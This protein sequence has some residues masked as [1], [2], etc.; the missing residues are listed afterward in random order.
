VRINAAGGTDIGRKRDH[1]EDSFGVFEGTGLY[2]VA[3]GMG[4]HAAGE[5][6]SR[7]AVDTVSGFIEASAGRGDITWPFG[8]DEALGRAGNR[9]SAAIKLANGAVR[10]RAGSAPELKGMGT[11]IVAALAE[12]GRLHIAHVG[13]SRAYMYS[14]G[15]LSRI[16]VDHSFVEEQVRAGMIAPEKA[17]SHPMRNIITRALGVKDD[18]SVDIM[19]HALTPGVIYLLCTDGLTGMVEDHEIERVMNAMC[20]D[21][22]ECADTLIAVANSNGGTDNI[23]VVLL[24]A[25]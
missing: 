24:R 1:N 17:R 9:L 2:I 23:T 12:E 4:G 18:V 7:I 11:T 20:D 8:L 25:E 16:T 6:A 22:R 5:L 10:D 19:D 3:D 14:G 15:R 21:L 13:D